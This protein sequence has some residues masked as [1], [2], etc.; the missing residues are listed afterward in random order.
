MITPR[1]VSCPE[2]GRK[3]G[4][5]LLAVPYLLVVCPCLESTS[6]FVSVLIRFAKPEFAGQQLK[7]H[8]GQLVRIASNL[9]IEV[10]MV[11]C[12]HTALENLSSLGSV[13]K[14]CR[15]PQRGSAITASPSFTDCTLTSPLSHQ[16]CVVDRSLRGELQICEPPFV[17]SIAPRSRELLASRPGA[18]QTL[19]SCRYSPS[20]A[21]VGLCRE[22]TYVFVTEREEGASVTKTHVEVR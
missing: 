7:R 8:R 1:G 15:N 20:L 10:W 22:S 3:S 12:I 17:D 4:R 21:A 19:T 13:K 16:S 14:A 18:L 2:S 9:A 5:R 11:V 6:R